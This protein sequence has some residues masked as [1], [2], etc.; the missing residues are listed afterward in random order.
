[1]DQPSRTRAP[2]PQLQW[3]IRSVDLRY[4]DLP[5]SALDGTDTG[6]GCDAVPLQPPRRRSGGG[7]RRSG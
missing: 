7:R 4:R 6:C 1:M 3:S 2:R 5:P